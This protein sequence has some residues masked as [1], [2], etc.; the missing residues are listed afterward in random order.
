MAATNEGHVTASAESAPEPKPVAKLVR[1]TLARPF[2]LDPRDDGAATLR[3]LVD[4]L[5]AGGHWHPVE[6]L[7]ADAA[8]LDTGFGAPVDDW[9]GLWS[10][11]V[12]FHPVVRDRLY[13]TEV[14]AD[15]SDTIVLA[16]EDVRGLQVRLLHGRQ[17]ATNPT[18]DFVVGRIRLHLFAFGVGVLWV[19]L[20]AKN[21]PL[22]DVI[23]TQDSIRRA[24]PPYWKRDKKNTPASRHHPL[25]AQWLDAKNTPLGPISDYSDVERYLKTFREQHRVALAPHWEW[26]LASWDQAN[27]GNAALPR[28]QHLAD[29]R[30]FTL[31]Y[32]AFDDVDRLTRGDWIRLAAV[33]EDG[34]SAT[35]PYATPFLADFEAK[36]FYDRYWDRT[37]PGA[38]WMST[39]YAATGYSFLAAGSYA[40]SEPRTLGAPEPGF[41]ADPVSGGLAHSRR[42]YA[43]IGL[44]LAV[45]SAAWTA[46]DEQISAAA[47]RLAGEGP[48]EDVLDEARRVHGRALDVATRWSFTEMSNQAQAKDLVALWRRNM[49]LDS[50]R[51]TALQHAQLLHDA[52]EQEEERRQTRESVK[53]TRVATS[54]IPFGLF[55]QFAVAYLTIKVSSDEARRWW[56]PKDDSLAAWWLIGAALFVILG[57]AW[58]FVCSVQRVRARKP[59]GLR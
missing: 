54:L 15:S 45:E 32:V 50:R 25:T 36:H 18:R 2:I 16:R 20:A 11:F 37:T 22:A 33:D 24:F 3:T 26:L 21:V 1:F 52:L 35:L 55:L 43:R 13:Q 27:P 30:I 7:L 51:A 44:L 47:S 29:D 34:P 10:E 48:T 5:T 53:L 46:L 14:G 40:E 59:G 8:T 19:E 9:E 17:A 42:H 28:V 49:T 12:Y 39:R 57:A 31:T 6:D 38:K 4:S 58:W 23:D 56:W 41:F